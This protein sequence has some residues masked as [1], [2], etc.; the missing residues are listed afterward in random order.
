MNEAIQWRPL[1]TLDGLRARARLNAEVRAF[2]AAREVLEVETPL[3]AACGV[4]DPGLYPFTT[5]FT[6]PGQCEGR[7]LYLQTSPEFAMKRLLAAGS[8][9]IYQIT[10]AF[11]NDEAGRHHNP[12][13]TLLEWY[14]VG[15]SLADLMDEVEALLEELAAGWR[16][17]LPPE[18]FT[19]VEAFG[20]ALGLHPLEASVAELAAVARALGLPEAA[21]LCGEDRAVWLDLL[22]S[23]FVQ[24]AL[25][26]K[27][28]T[29][30]HH[31][32][33]CLP[34]LARRCEA[35][36][37]FVERVEIFMEGIELGN[38]FHELTDP[39]EQRR[40]F[41]LDLER[42]RSLNLPEPGIDDRLLEALQAGLPPCSG[43]A[44]GLDRL[45]MV[46]T[47]AGHIADVLAFPIE[48]A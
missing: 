27:R 29:S 25:G 22:F 7:R 36:P 47:G 37:R 33:A 10:K 43:I 40:R 5:V 9:S 35:D 46:L 12:E 17:P 24:P 39:V 23:H 44:L 19:Y 3:L 48:R 28:L 6:L 42:R 38:G 11:R 32:P 4:T 26:S 2:F 16:D 20:G 31:C 34:S 41:E 15:Y 18:R 8:G 45:L 14:R 1:C 21:E 30:I 13:F